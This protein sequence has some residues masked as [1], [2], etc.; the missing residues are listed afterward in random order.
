MSLLGKMVKTLVLLCSPLN[1]VTTQKHFSF[2]FF[3]ALIKR[4]KQKNKF[5]GGKGE[6]RLHDR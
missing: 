1:K 6:E 4:T 2:T 5:R 3:V